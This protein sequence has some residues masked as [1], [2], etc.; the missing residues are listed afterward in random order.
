MNTRLTRIILLLILAIPPQTQAQGTSQK[1][2]VI[3]EENNGRRSLNARIEDSILFA[4]FEPSSIGISLKQMVLTAGEG[5]V[6]AVALPHIIHR[7]KI[8]RVLAKTVLAY[9]AGEIAYRGLL[10]CY[11]KDPEILPLA[12][13]AGAA[14]G[15]RERSYLNDGE[16]Q[17]ID[18]SF[19]TPTNGAIYDDEELVLEVVEI[20]AKNIFTD[21]PIPTPKKKYFINVRQFDQHVNRFILETTNYFSVP[22]RAKNPKLL[23]SGR[24]INQ[25]AKLGYRNQYPRTLM[26]PNLVIVE[27]MEM[28]LVFNQQIDDR[29]LDLEK[30]RV[31]GSQLVT[32]EATDRDS[33]MTTEFTVK[34]TIRPRQDLANQDLA[35]CTPEPYETLRSIKSI[36][37]PKYGEKRLRAHSGKPKAN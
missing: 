14:L 36:T 13:L 21:E 6:A 9:T 7:K 23:V 8:P 15:I 18:R 35:T 17:Y 28:D 29:F 16:L 32:F 2:S 24:A 11:G 27:F 31:E 3:E 4:P 34:A 25:G 37:S 22:I 1:S 10:Q 5:G 19:E 20:E 30:I 33:S 12:H 26:Y